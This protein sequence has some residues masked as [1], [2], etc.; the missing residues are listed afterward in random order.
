MGC[1]QRQ[2]EISKDIVDNYRTMFESRISAGGVEAKRRE[3]K[4]REAKRSEEKR[5]EEKRREEK[6][7]EEKRREEKQSSTRPMRNA[8]S[9]GRMCSRGLSQPCRISLP[10]LLAML[11]ASRLMTVIM[12]MSTRTRGN[13]PKSKALSLRALTLESARVCCRCTK[14]KVLGLPACVL[15]SLAT[16][17]WTTPGYGGSIL[18]TARFW[19]LTSTLT[20][21]AFAW[22]VLAPWNPSLA[23]PATRAF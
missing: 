2:C 11:A 6:R 5:R 19:K 1:T 8:I 21:S 22:V 18:A 10:R 14:V 9:R 13:E 17:L 23:P 16:P 15:P 20:R 12:M 4:R 7:R 3:E